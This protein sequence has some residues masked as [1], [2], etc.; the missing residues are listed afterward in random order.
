MVNTRA[1]KIRKIEKNVTNKML[2]A[3]LKQHPSTVSRKINGKLDMSLEDA[4]I[5]QNDLEIPDAQF[6]YYF[7]NRESHNATQ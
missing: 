1:L 5:I 7:F 2:A 4:E 3:K 6:G